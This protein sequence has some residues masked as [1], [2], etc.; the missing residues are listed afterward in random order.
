M[1]RLLKRP[2]SPFWYV[3]FKDCSGKICREST[4]CR[5]DTREGCRA[6]NRILSK[7][8]A[9]EKQAKILPRNAAFDQWVDGY[10]RQHATNPL[11]LKVYLNRWNMLTLFFRSCGIEYP[12]QVTYALC[13]DYLTW[14]TAGKEIEAVS[15]NTARDDLGTLRFIMAEAVR[16]EFAVANPCLNLRIKTVARKEKQE[17]SDSDIEAVRHELETGLQPDNQ[18]RWPDWQRLQFE[19]GLHTGR[20]IAETRIPMSSINLERGEYTV[21]VKGGKIKTKPIHPDL[22]P[23]LKAVKGEYTL[24]AGASHS[25]RMWRKLFD[26]LGMGF[27]FHSL[28]VS[29]VSRCRRS[30]VDRWT[31]LQLCDHA[32]GVVHQLYN[33]WADADLRTALAK[34]EFP[35]QPSVSPES[36]QEKSCHPPSVSLPC[37]AFD[38]GSSGSQHVPAALVP[39]GIL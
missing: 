14:R 33:R 8:A 20:R 39:G 4:K 13:N 29:F 16:R 38:T 26:K 21:R 31:A 34:L 27:S 25:S 17:L 11:T 1:A 3:E 7:R 24:T 32:S 28:R 15:Q 19:I 2:R 35:K 9:E 12:A 18:C 23:W 22:L 36:S 10:L 37:P 5:C 30:G 6:A